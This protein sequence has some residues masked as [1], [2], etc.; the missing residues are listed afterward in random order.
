M[1]A[2]A[3]GSWAADAWAGTAWD[4]TA[5][6]FGQAWFA[7][8]WAAG[9]WGAAAWAN[10]G[11]PPPSDWEL[12][13]PTIGPTLA[14]TF[15]ASGDFAFG[16]GVIFSLAPTGPVALSGTFDAAGNFAFSDAPV[17]TVTITIRLVDAPVNG[18][19]LPNLTN[20]LWGVWENAA[21]ESET[22]GIPPT[23]SGTTES[24]DGSGTIQLQFTSAKTSGQAVLV[25]TYKHG[26]PPRAMTALF[27]ID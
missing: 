15:G 23:A 12:E 26:N 22:W 4:E 5:P 1:P 16:S 18:Q 13:V 17:A 9:S 19:P 27:A 2:W 6:T 11:T 20:I 25:K 24:T 8:A 14:G 3:P 10:G 21:D 7:T